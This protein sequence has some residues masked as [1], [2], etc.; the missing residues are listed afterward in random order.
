MSKEQ[1]EFRSADHIAEAVEVASN[2]V[3]RV[4][5]LMSR[6][7]IGKP[8]RDAQLEMVKM[9]SRLRDLVDMIVEAKPA[10][11]EDDGRVLGGPVQDGVV[12]AQPSNAGAVQEAVAVKAAVVVPGRARSKA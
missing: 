7:A 11:P 6:R 1:L 10:P 9:A 2:A 5:F 4:A 8:A 3:N 12:I